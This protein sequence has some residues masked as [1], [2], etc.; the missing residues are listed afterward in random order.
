MPG[1]VLGF[2]EEE[3]FVI[4]EEGDDEVGELLCDPPPLELEDSQELKRFMFPEEVVQVCAGRGWLGF[5]L[6]EVAQALAVGGGR[7]CSEE[8]AKVCTCRAGIV[9]RGGAGYVLT[10]L[11]EE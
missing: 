7:L 8:Q 5:T 11:G 2:N 10:H 4:R 9:H 6:T 3:S 1:A